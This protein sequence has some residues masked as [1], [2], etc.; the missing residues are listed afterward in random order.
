MPKTKRGYGL[1]W[2]GSGHYGLGHGSRHRTYGV[3]PLT[4]RTRHPNTMTAA[5]TSPANSTKDQNNSQAE[6]KAT[7]TQDSANLSSTGPNMGSAQ[8]TTRPIRPPLPR[9]RVPSSSQCS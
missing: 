3:S 7:T 6:N 9:P 1:V 4:L 5:N 2:T 8:V